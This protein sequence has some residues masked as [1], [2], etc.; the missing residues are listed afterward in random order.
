MLLCFIQA[1]TSQS[2]DTASPLSKLDRVKLFVEL[3]VKTIRNEDMLAIVTFGT[4]ARVVQPLRRM[5]DDVKVGLIYSITRKPI[6]NAKVS[7]RQPW[8]IGRNSLGLNRPSLRNAQ[9]Y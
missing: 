5:T 7:A 3:L 9:Q 6:A 1:S 8:Y 4:T 2:S